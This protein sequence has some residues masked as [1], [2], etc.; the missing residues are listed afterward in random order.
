MAPSMLTVGNGG[1]P[2]LPKVA[3]G[4]PPAMDPGCPHPSL[5]CNMRFTPTRN[6]TWQL[7][8]Q[9]CG[10]H[11]GGPDLAKCPDTQ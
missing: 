3:E 9:L 8:S 10:N 4:R 2:A 5:L 7:G 6:R 11:V 1:R